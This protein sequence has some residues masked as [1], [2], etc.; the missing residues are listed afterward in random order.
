MSMARLP[1]ISLRACAIISPGGVIQLDKIAPKAKDCWDL[2]LKERPGSVGL[3]KLAGWRC[4]RIVV[5]T[6]GSRRYVI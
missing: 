5:K 6:V 1:V 4:T 3:L 2:L